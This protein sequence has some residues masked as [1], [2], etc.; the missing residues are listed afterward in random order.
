MIYRGEASKAAPAGGRSPDLD[1]SGGV[2]P[3]IF[4]PGQPP[5][6]ARE[7]IDALGG[8]DAF[9]KLLCVLKPASRT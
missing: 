4:A 5:F 3:R 6:P 8:S 1:A 9:G 7:A 2:R